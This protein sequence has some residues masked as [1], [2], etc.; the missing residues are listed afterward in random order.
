MAAAER[1]RLLEVA[2]ICLADAGPPVVISGPAVGMVMMTVREPVESTRFHLAE[3]LVTKAE[4]DHRGHRGWSM[5]M[6]DDRLAALAAA[7]CDAEAAADGRCKVFI[8]ELCATTE[9]K[10]ERQRRAEWNDLQPTIVRFE[11]LT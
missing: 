2:D 4:V 3:V 5:R 6:G 11:E 9:T 10:L 8:D 1:P 7:V